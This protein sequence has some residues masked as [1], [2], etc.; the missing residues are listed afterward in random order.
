MQVVE[1]AKPNFDIDETWK[2][3]SYDTTPRY[4]H[5]DETHNEPYFTSLCKNCHI[6]EEI[7][8]AVNQTF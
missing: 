8:L 7:L 6:L 5:V 4:L 3:S 2:L 1:P